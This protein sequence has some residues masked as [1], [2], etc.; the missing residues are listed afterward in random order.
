MARSVIVKRCG[1]HDGRG[2][3]RGRDEDPVKLTIAGMAHLDEFSSTVEMFLQVV[4]ALVERRAAAAFEPNRVITVEVSGPQLVKDL[5]LESE[6]LVDLLPELLEGEPAAWHGT[7]NSNA[8]GWVHRPSS[9]LRRFRGVR[10][11]NDYLVRIRTWIMPAQPVA[12]PE[13]VSPLSLVTAFDYLDVVWR[14]RF[15]RQ[16]VYVPSAERATRLTL[17]AATA[18]EFDSRLS[19]LGEMFKGL[20]VPGT[21]AGTFDRMRAFLNAKLPTEAM[22]RVTPAIATLQKVTHIRNAGQHVGASRQAAEALP[23]LGITFP[24]VDHQTAWRAVQ[25]HVV[26]ALDTLRVEI[27][28]TIPRASR[29]LTEAGDSGTPQARTRRGRYANLATTD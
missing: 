26:Q 3:R 17:D 23:T 14:L 8:D 4:N 11:V 12:V 16:L 5:H 7:G 1:C 15:G 6:L 10:D 13:S 27:H 21:G 22:A 19:A 18:D 29:R 25:A 2:D 28:T 24:I 20:D 9:F